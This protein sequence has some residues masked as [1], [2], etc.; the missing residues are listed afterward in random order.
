MPVETFDIIVR[1]PLSPSLASTVDGFDATF[2][3]DGFTHLVGEIENKEQLRRVRQL[4]VDQE[5]EVVSARPV[6][7]A[8]HAH[9]SDDHPRQPDAAAVDSSSHADGAVQE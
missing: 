6:R 2:C 1:G 5:V 7:G 9:L 4:L 8:F 3:K